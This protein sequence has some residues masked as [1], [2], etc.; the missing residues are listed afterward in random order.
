MPRIDP[1]AVAPDT[2]GPDD[3]CGPGERRALGEAGGLDQFGVAV[4]TLEPGSRSSDRHWHSDEDEFLIVL[5]GE[6]TLVEDGGEETLRPGDC[7]AWAAGVPVGH[8]VENRSDAPLRFLVVGTR[9]A[10]DVCTYSDLDKV[11][12]KDDGGVRLTRRD[13]SPL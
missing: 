4:E 9:A 12:I 1:A 5:E 13:G 6:G 10:R 8:C 7:A 2:F 3:P 11:Q